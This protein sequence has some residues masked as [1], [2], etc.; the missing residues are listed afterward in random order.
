MYI[1]TYG[2]RGT[3]LDTCLKSPFSE[4]PSTSNMVKEPKHTSK[5]SDSTFTILIDPCK[6]IQV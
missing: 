2:V 3:W 6:G 5:L 1:R 4:S